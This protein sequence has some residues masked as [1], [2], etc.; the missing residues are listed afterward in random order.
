MSPEYPRQWIPRGPSRPTDG[1]SLPAQVPFEFETELFKGRAVIYLRGLENTPERVFKGKARAIQFSV[2][3]RFKREVA[4]DDLHFGLSLA[5]PLR[6]LPT[7]WLLNLCTRVVQSL[8]A[9]YSMDLSDPTADRPYMLAP[10]ILAAQTVS[11]AAPGREPDLTLAPI[12]ENARLTFLGHGGKGVGANERRRKIA[13]IIRDAKHARR[14]AG[15]GEQPRRVDARRPGAVVRRRLDVDVFVL[16]VADRR[17]QVLRGPRRGEIR[18]GAHHGRAAHR[19]AVPDER[20][21]SRRVQVR[22]LARAIAAARA[23]ASIAGRRRA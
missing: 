9:Q 1:V 4:M 15:V 22:G 12:E 17:V 19:A 20:R 14:K 8:G 7:R 5:R 2:Q 16:A 13:K 18:P 3:G 11:C 23:L 6:N 21:V 10:I